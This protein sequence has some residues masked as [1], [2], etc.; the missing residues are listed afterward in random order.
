MFGKLRSPVIMISLKLSDSEDSRY[1]FM[2]ERRSLVSSEQASG[3]GGRY[4]L[5]M[6]V[7]MLLTVQMIASHVPSLWTATSL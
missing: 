2:N 4:T 5:A 3:G 1:L 6:I 7:T